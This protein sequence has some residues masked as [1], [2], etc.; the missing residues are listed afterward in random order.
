LGFVG[1]GGIG[2]DLYRA[3]KNFDHTDISAIALM[4]IVAVMLIDAIC[5]WLRGR[6]IGQESLRVL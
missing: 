5:G 1:A 3:I 6:V 4:L 2:Q